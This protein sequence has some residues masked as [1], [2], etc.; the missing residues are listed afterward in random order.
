M[1]FKFRRSRRS[2]K[3]FPG[4][5]INTGKKGINSVSIGGRGKIF[6]ATTNIKLK[7]GKTKS[8]YSLKGVGSVVHTPSSSSNSTLKKKSAALPEPKPGNESSIKVNQIISP[9]RAWY[10]NTA[11]VALSAIFFPPIGIPLVCISDLDDRTKVTLSIASV[12][13]LMAVY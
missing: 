3:V 1:G 13:V 4:V 9:Q 8:T 2:I 7:T 5:R 6:G 12:I 10:Q 11:V